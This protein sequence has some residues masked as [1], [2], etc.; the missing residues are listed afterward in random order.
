MN[1]LKFVHT[2]DLHLDSPFRGVAELDEHVA[3]ELREATFRTF[4]SIV[5][6]CLERQV[7]FLLVAG[8]VYDSHDRSLR[9]QLR[10]RDGLKQLSE[11]GISSFVVHGNH[12]ALDTWS[13]SLRWPERVH[14]I[15]GNRVTRL[16]AQSNSFTLAHVYGV[17]Y[18]KREVRLNLAKQFRRQDKQVFSIGLLH[19]NVGV[20]TGHEPYAPCALE[21]LFD[22]GMD[23]WAL[24]H[25]H[26]H[27]VLCPEGPT[28]IYPGNPQG[29]NPREQGARGCYFVE[30]D[31]GRRIA[32]EFVP[33][34]TVR[35]YWKSLSIERI[36]D[37][38]QLVSALET[39]CEAVR[40]EADGRPVVLR[41]TLAGRSA[42]HGSLMRVGFVDDLVQ[43][44][45]ETEGQEVPFVWVE[46]IC[47][48]ARP[49]L[50][51]DERRT[52]QDFVGDL[53]RL[54]KT[55]REDPESLQSL[56]RQLAPLFDSRRGRQLLR[57]LSEEEL[58]ECLE[59]AEMRCVDLL[60]P[61]E[62]Q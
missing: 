18:P 38:D 32:V 31:G 27:A 51:L 41:V 6:L 46:R 54:A 26:N 33:V 42:M 2:A 3:R 34:D 47:V 50:D 62:E 13:P 30:V 14:M 15:G 59:R 35:W 29:L 36:E 55:Y 45:R 7:H 20:N 58:R 11:A 10:F 21:D 12:D 57:P 39:L 37:E 60:V 49:P 56:R 17:S 28:V 43:R 19:C 24:G 61:E 53:L 44:L 22:A 9:A 48:S 1:R 8:D 5:H 16:S 4:E 25:V 23:Y 52:G 40:D